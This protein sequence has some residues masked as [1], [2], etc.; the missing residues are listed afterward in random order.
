MKPNKNKNKN[1]KEPPKTSKW[2]LDKILMA[3]PPILVISGIAIALNGVDKGSLQQEIF[4]LCFLPGT[5]IL[6]TPNVVAYAKKDIKKWKSE[7]F[8]D[9]DGDCFKTAIMREK[10]FY[11]VSDPSPYHDT[12]VK[13]VEREAKRSFLLLI[14]CLILAF[15]GFLYEALPGSEL[16]EH[17]KYKYIYEYGYNRNWD[18][19]EVVDGEAFLL[20][21]AVIVLLIPILAYYITRTRC[22]LRM[23]RNGEYM[24]FHTVVSEAEWMEISIRSE[25]KNGYSRIFKFVHCKFLGIKA[26]KIHDTEAVLI[27]VPDYEYLIPCKNN[28]EF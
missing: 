6:I 14:I 2:Y 28:M 24:A 21:L 27:L 18:I 22:R 3:L 8:K 26:R 16:S 5:G 13:G 4:G 1:K 17:T 12:L 19:D 15:F 10:F 23:I 7:T 11:P 20:L 25:E 9:K